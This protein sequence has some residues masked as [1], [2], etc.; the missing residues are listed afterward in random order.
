MISWNLFLLEIYRMVCMWK[1]VY[2]VNVAKCQFNTATNNILQ[3]YVYCI[4]GI[5]YN[6]TTHQI[7]ILYNYTR[8]YIYNMQSISLLFLSIALLYYNILY[9]TLK[10]EYI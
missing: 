4:L 9:S 7:T 1:Y 8:A 3:I 10:Y 5:V 6:H 2:I